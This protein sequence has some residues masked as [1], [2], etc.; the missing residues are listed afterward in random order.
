MFT[1]EQQENH[2]RLIFGEHDE[3]LFAV[4]T[5][6]C[7][8]IEGK[9]IAGAS[10]SPEHAEKFNF[11]EKF[12]LIRHTLH[13]CIGRCVPKVFVSEK[14]DDIVENPSETRKYAIVTNLKNLF[15]QLINIYI[16]DT[17]ILGDYEIS[18]KDTIIVPIGT[19][20]K[21]SCKAKIIYYD[22]SKTNIGVAVN[23]F[24][25][26]NSGYTV[27]DGPQQSSSDDYTNDFI[28]NGSGGE[29]IRINKQD[30]DFWY[31]VIKTLN[32]SFG[33]HGFPKG[34]SWQGA[35]FSHQEDIIGNMLYLL[36]GSQC[37]RDDL[38]SLLFLKEFGTIY[39]RRLINWVTNTDRFADSIKK[40]FLSFQEQFIDWCK[41]LSVE[42]H[43]IKKHKKT[44]MTSSDK[45]I[46]SWFINN[47]HKPID[48]LC[49]YA[50]QV[51]SRF[52]EFDN[53]QSTNCDNIYFLDYIKVNDLLD[54]DY[55]SNNKKYIFIFLVNL[56]QSWEY[57]QKYNKIK[58]NLIFNDDAFTSLLLKFDNVFRSLKPVDI[59][60]GDETTKDLLYN[61]FLQFRQEYISINNKESVK[62]DNNEVQ[63]SQDDLEP[64]NKKAKISARPTL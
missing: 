52:A 3:K 14:E 58:Y 27:T 35:Y 28:F 39:S 36:S 62:P 4:H 50:D 37:D 19:D 6:D 31:D 47:L 45:K 42:I 46:I 63:V 40:Q 2:K 48:E 53:S 55:L 9:Q 18:E 7:L 21:N 25:K 57:E 8:P 1:A 12:P 11:L 15:P 17:F 56:F 49:S 20:F 34:G 29:E 33:R 22:P 24:I 23:T 30:P 32:I 44:L 38:E 26:S 60:I 16:D 43:L 54:S 61:V 10:L 41:L 64:Q 13:W 51:N 5:T 59:F